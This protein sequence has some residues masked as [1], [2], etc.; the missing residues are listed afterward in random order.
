MPTTLLHGGHVITDPAALLDGG[1]ITNGGVLVVGEQVEAVGPFDALHKAHP[2]AEV[3]GSAQHLVMPGLINAHHHGAG[4]MSPH[5]GIR[6]DYL[7]AWLPDNRR[8][9][10]LDIYLDTLYATMR[11]I[12][13]G[14]TCVL[15]MAYPRD[16]WDT[17]EESRNTLRAYA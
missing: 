14:V 16:W 17:G 13:S 9:P 11:L 3:V 1:V 2:E 10:P 4:V 5:F 7:E 6:D 15:H 12:R 8:M